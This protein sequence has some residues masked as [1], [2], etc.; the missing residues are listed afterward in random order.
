MTPTRSLALMVLLVVAGCTKPTTFPEPKTPG[1]YKADASPTVSIPNPATT[2]PAGVAKNFLAAA[3]AGTATAAMLTPEFKKV[4]AP[5]VYQDDH[6]KGYSDAAA[7]GWLKRFQGRLASPQL[8]AAQGAGFTG[9]AGAEKFVLRVAN[10]QIDW[11]QA[12]PGITQW[13]HPVVEPTKADEQFVAVAFLT[14][15]VGK[16]DRLAAGL[17]APALREHLAPPFSSDKIGYN[18]GILEGKLAQLRGGHTGFALNALTGDTAVAGLIAEGTPGKK[19][20]TLKLAKGPRP[21]EWLVADV[22]AE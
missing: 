20:L 13:A 9:S 2:D 4:V 17:M 1:G 18:R 22:I 10:G 12:T 21:G 5:A 16:D 6:A 11:F 7:D 3:N 14:A 15:L 8:S 19:S